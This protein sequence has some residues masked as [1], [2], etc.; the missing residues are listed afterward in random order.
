MYR[1]APH[2]TLCIV[3]EICTGRACLFN[4]RVQPLR[5]THEPIKRCERGLE[6]LFKEFLLLTV[7]CGSGWVKLLISTRC[8]APYGFETNHHTIQCVLE[9][10]GSAPHPMTPFNCHRS[11]SSLSI[12]CRPFRCRLMTSTKK[13]EHTINMIVFFVDASGREE[14]DIFDKYGHASVL[15]KPIPIP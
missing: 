3:L 12:T 2:F 5:W 8:P 1:V 10:Y 6:G 13:A 4:N 7:R 11:Q 15:N 9:P 14:S